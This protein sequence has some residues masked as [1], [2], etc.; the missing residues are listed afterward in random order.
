MKVSLLCTPEVKP[1]GLATSDVERAHPAEG[2]VANVLELAADRVYCGCHQDVGND[3]VQVPGC[4][5]SRRRTR[6]ARCTASRSRGAQDIVALLPEFIVVR[7]S[8]TVLLSMRLQVRVA[9]KCAI[10][11]SR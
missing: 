11:S 2:A 9:E 10:R 5:S 7:R 8:G 4:L 6:C 1:R 3:A